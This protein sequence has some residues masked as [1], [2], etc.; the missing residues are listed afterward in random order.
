[1]NNRRNENEIAYQVNLPDFESIDIRP[2]NL[3]EDLLTIH[4]WFNRDHAHFWGLVGK[5]VEK[6]RSIYQERLEEEG[7]EVFIG[8]YSS[9][10][11]P[12]FLLHL[13]EPKKDGLAEY[14]DAQDSDRGTH[15]FLAPVAVKIPNFTQNIFAAIC[16]FA[17]HYPEVQRIVA[18]PDIR[19]EKQFIACKRAGYSL[20]SVIYLP[21][22]TCQLVF[23]TREQYSNV[24][25]QPTRSKEKFL[26]RPVWVKFHV[27]IGKIRRRLIKLGF[28]K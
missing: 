17:F 27:L 1:M 13:Y 28:L 24:R 10:Q 20:G 4:D 22:K 5:S 12:L 2:L 8:E 15:Q 18:E 19:N 9:S 3:D 16:E 7:H 11:E 26:F 21:N 14:Y 6:V 25:R 23:L